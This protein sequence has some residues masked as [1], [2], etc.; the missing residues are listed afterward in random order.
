M[1]R[2]IIVF[3]CILTVFLMISTVTAVSQANSEIVMEK[4]DELNSHILENY[5]RIEKIESKSIWDLI[6]W[7]IGAILWI[8]EKILYLI[9]GII[10]E[11]IVLILGF[12]LWILGLIFLLPIGFV[13]IFIGVILYIFGAKEVGSDL[14]SFGLLCLK[15]WSEC[16]LILFWPDTT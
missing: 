15:T 11:I 16:F 6:E 7:I 1:K 10:L 13:C 8:V 12:I 14:V 2:K 9:V 4:V 5:K 3:G